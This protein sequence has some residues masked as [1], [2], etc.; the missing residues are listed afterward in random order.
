M[1]LLPADMLGDSRT[2]GC[3][4]CCR[5]CLCSFLV[6]LAVLILGASKLIIVEIRAQITGVFAS[7]STDLDAEVDVFASRLQ[8]QP[9]MTLCEMGS[10][11]G[12]FMSR[13]APRVMPGGK[14]FAT[15]PVRQELAAT[16]NAVDAAGIDADHVLT[17][18]H[19]NDYDWAPG[20]PLG[21]CDALYSR[22]VIHMLPDE[23]FKR[24]M[25]QWARALKPGARMFMTDHNPVM[26]ARTTGPKRPMLAAFEGKLVLM[27]M[28]VWPQETEVAQITSTHF[29]LI[30]G[31]FPH[32][33]YAGGYGAVYTPRAQPIQ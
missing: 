13:L 28:D 32:D 12:T 30:D 15:S 18:L 2:S 17:T 1:R 25:A 29:D 23:T 31:P 16:A 22:M 4:S 3:S 5:W 14:L 21:A 8:L 11:D 24:Y 19:A 10:A 9:G 26:P 27:P 33:F 20:L 7:S 6:G